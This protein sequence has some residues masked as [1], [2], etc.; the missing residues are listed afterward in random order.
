MRKYLFLFMIFIIAGQVVLAIEASGDYN[1]NAS[2]TWYDGDYRTDF[3]DI[4]NIDLYLLEI[5]G[6]R[7]QYSFTVTDPLLDLLEDGTLPI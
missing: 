7:L 5:A 2:A 6:S 4:L 1:I 3:N